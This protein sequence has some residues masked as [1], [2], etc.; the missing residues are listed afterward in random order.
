MFLLQMTSDIQLQKGSRVRSWVSLLWLFGNLFGT[1]LYFFKLFLFFWDWSQP[2][3]FA[4]FTWLMFISFFLCLSVHTI[5]WP[6]EV[7][8]ILW[9]FWLWSII[10]WTH[11]HPHFLHPFPLMPHPYTHRPSLHNRDWFARAHATAPMCG[12]EEDLGN[13]AEDSAQPRLGT[14]K[15]KWVLPSNP[16]VQ[17]AAPCY[18]ELSLD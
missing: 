17:P 16:S 4:M 2:P 1:D 3:M 6:R 12:E 5:T 9:S 13:T 10:L 18:Q 7:I 15:V 8:I 11:S 14:A